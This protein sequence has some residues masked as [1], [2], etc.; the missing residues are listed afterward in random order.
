MN[1]LRWMAERHKKDKEYELMTRDEAKAFK[2]DEF[3]IQD[4]RKVNVEK[5]YESSKKHIARKYEKK[6]E[7]A[8]KRGEMTRD[9][10]K[11]VSGGH[12]KI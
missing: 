4:W 6:N 2:E 7:M 10:W 9:Q 1:A 8:D 3:F 12:A 11:Q 5:Q